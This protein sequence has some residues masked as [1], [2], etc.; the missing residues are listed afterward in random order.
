MRFPGDVVAGGSGGK[1][2]PLRFP[3]D[4]VTRGNATSQG[5]ERSSLKSVAIASAT[6]FEIAN[7]CATT[8]VVFVSSSSVALILLLE[9]LGDL[10][11]INM[12]YYIYCR[13]IL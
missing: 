1:A 7:G 12:D 9:R 11:G 3:C 4:G 8:S 10:S 2:S 5:L 6:I 13:T